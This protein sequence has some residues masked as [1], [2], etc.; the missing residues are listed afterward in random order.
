MSTTPDQTTESKVVVINPKLRIA[1]DHSFDIAGREFNIRT[2]RTLFSDPKVQEFISQRLRFNNKLELFAAIDGSMHAYNALF[3]YLDAL[4]PLT[5][6]KPIDLYLTGPLTDSDE[7]QLKLAFSFKSRGINLTYS[8]DLKGIISPSSKKFDVA[9][10]IGMLSDQVAGGVTF[11]SQKLKQAVKNDGL[12]ALDYASLSTPM[13]GG[14]DKNIPK[15]QLDVN[16]VIGAL[17][18]VSFVGIGLQVQNINGDEELFNLSQSGI[19]GNVIREYLQAGGNPDFNSPQT[20]MAVLMALG[21]L[22]FFYQVMQTN[23][24]MLNAMLLSSNISP[25][26]A[27]ELINR[28][29]NVQNDIEEL[30][31]PQGDKFQAINNIIEKV[32][33]SNSHESYETIL[34]HIY[35]YAHVSLGYVIFQSDTSYLEDE[36]A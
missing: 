32:F 33:R 29:A 27:Q 35:G 28:Y 23:P 24:E 10:G 22:M 26:M 18:N 17:L 31:D 14:L 13:R 16:T 36:E 30:T 3:T 19:H 1:Y 11:V 25:E 21:S 6:D 7:E 20:Q 5:K 15:T 9:L 4:R 8:P 34:R 12:V 2:S